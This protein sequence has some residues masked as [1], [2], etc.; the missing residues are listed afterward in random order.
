MKR[1]VVLGVILIA[2]GSFTP[3]STKYNPT[4]SQTVWEYK[5]V[6]LSY[7]GSISVE[8]Q[9]NRL[10][11]EGWELVDVAVKYGDGSADGN[12]FFKRPK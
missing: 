2:L 9:I 7:S 10:G 3:G 11:N 12:Y 4:A 8:A 1:I 5:I 6:N